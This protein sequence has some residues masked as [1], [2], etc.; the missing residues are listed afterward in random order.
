MEQSMCFQFEWPLATLYQGVSACGDACDQQNTMRHCHAMR[1]FEDGEQ[2]SED[3]ELLAAEALFCCLGSF[4]SFHCPWHLCHLS[5][6]LS[7]V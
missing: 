3:T 1:R 7:S 6:P 5:L 4:L 2:D